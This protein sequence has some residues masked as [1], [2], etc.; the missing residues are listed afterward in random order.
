MS[1]RMRNGAVLP[2]GLLGADPNAMM[3]GFKKSHQNTSLRFGMIVATYAKDDDRNVTGLAP[4]YDVIVFEQNENKGSTPI[5][6]K[7]CLSAEGLGSIADFFEKTLRVQNR[8]GN[9][10]D[11]KN[12]NGAIVIVL[13]LN[14]V[15][16][17]GIIIGALTHPD[18]TSTLVDDGPRLEGEYNGVNIKVEKDG[19][20]TLTFKGATDNDGK[21]IDSSQGPTELKIEKDG[22][23]QI[24]HKTITQRFDKSGVA[25]LT[26]QDNITNDTQKSFN[27]NAQ[28]DVNV[29]ANNNINI[30]ALQL[31]GTITGSCAFTCASGSMVSS[32]TFGIKG[33]T[34]S[35]EAESIAQIKAP[36]VVLDG[37]VYLGGTGGLP[38]LTLGTTFFGIGNLGM[39]V[40]SRAIAGFSSK[41]SAV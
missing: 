35:G 22:S 1:A 7:N 21:I 14:G 10:V 15:S 5:T 13:C 36:I 20:T 3:E 34:F 28:Q 31:V 32:G 11:T 27:V 41:A 8:K 26:A 19:S 18:R 6:Y 33:A 30:T 16:D 29:N 25:S 39:P 2:T 37:Q 12:Q 4:E 40:L 9:N 38:V 24:D 17:K 23:Y